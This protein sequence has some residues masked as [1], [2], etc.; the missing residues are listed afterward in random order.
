MV[1]FG[2]KKKNVVTLPHSTQR[3]HAFFV[4]TKEKANS[5]KVAPKNKSSLELLQHRLGHRTTISLMAGNNA[6]I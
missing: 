6:H 4:K 2:D 3:K 1:Y 5:K